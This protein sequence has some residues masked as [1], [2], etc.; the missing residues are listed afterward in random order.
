MRDV[1]LLVYA[2]VSASNT[3]LV[4]KRF[5]SP[6]AYLLQLR[7]LLPRQI[8]STVAVNAPWSPLPQRPPELQHM[9]K[10]LLRA[11]LEQPSLTAFITKAP[12]GINSISASE[13]ATAPS[14]PSSTPPQAKN[15][16]R[17]TKWWC[18]IELLRDDG[19]KSSFTCFQHVPTVA[20][21]IA[22]VPLTFALLVISVQLLPPTS[23]PQALQCLASP[24]MWLA[25]PLPWPMSPA[26]L[27][28]ERLSA[29]KIAP[30]FRRCLRY[31]RVTNLEST[32]PCLSLFWTPRARIF[33]RSSL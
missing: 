26:S 23:Q 28:K 10:L 9:L 3:K 19:G 13:P 15:T 22:T 2:P 7:P 17:A 33:L 8:S 29:A 18:E 1:L 20:A 21:Y 11:L 5:P 32:L 16:K 4:T 6:V 14:P 12:L 24:P 27:S 25:S 31:K 30:Q